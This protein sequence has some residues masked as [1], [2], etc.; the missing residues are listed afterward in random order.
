MELDVAVQKLKT[1][2]KIHNDNEMFLQDKIISIPTDISHCEKNIEKI[3]EDIELV[4]KNPT[5]KDTFSIEIQGEIFTDK[6]DAGQKLIDISQN[7]KTD[8]KIDVGEYRGFNLQL[9]ASL[10][11]QKVHLKNNNSYSVD[12]DKSPIGNIQRIDNGL[13]KLP[14]RLENLQNQLNVLKNELE[15]AKREIG[16]PFEKQAEYD[17]K[18]Q[19]LSI[20]NQEIENIESKPKDEK[21]ID[22]KPRDNQEKTKPKEKD[23]R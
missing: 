21:S 6:K 14:N 19:R 3:V 23:S 4:T 13:E 16:K 12:I 10:N 18:S 9:S 20:V 11:T 8:D 17:Q 22:D 15:L 7:M 5:S 2:K 1:A